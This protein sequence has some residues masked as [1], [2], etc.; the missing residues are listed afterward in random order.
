[1]IINKFS[2]SDLD[3]IFS[4]AQGQ[5]PYILESLG[6]NSSFLK[7]KHGPCPMCGGKDRFRF[8]DKEKGAFICNN[9]GAGFGIKLLQLYH[10]WSFNY[11]VDMVARVIRFQATPYK[12]TKPQPILQ[13]LKNLHLDQQLPKHES[14]KRKYK[15]KKLWLESSPVTFDD[16]VDQYLQAR[17]MRLSKFPYALRFYADLPYYENGAFK[18]KYEAM[19]ALIT[20]ENGKGI[21]IHRTYLKEG[22]KADVPQPKKLMPSIQPGA[23][24]G[25]AIKLFEPQNGVLALAEGIETALSIH[26]ATQLPV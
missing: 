18:G 4:E 10:N 13:F 7:N 3:L 21:S 25:A 26:V 22:H 6:V 23:T 5:W 9:C 1:M 2:R 12:S 14:E 11:A 16:P 20:D 19:L 8:D 15:L 17:G 24:Q